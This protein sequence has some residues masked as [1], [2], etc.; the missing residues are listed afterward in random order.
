MC[1][2]F[3]LSVVSNSYSQGKIEIAALNRVT[4]NHD[5]TIYQ[6]YAVKPQIKIKYHQEKNYYWYVK[7]TILIT[8]SGLDG[9]ILNGTFKIFYPDKNIMEEGQ[10]KYGL[11]T[12]LWKSWYPNGVLRLTVNWLSGT[13]N[14]D[15]EEFDPSG[16]K[17][18]SGSYKNNFFTG[19]VF[20]Y[21]QNGSSQKI[22][23][24]NGK[25]VEKPI[26]EPPKKN[27]DKKL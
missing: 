26:T 16:R 14:G 13:I 9:R 1:C 23:Y 24:Q 2:L 6:F 8:Q 7:D 15:F 25:I 21:L 3:F 20:I 18:R 27:N 4:L 5:D 12:G 11:K 22:Y 19:H 10:F 17:I